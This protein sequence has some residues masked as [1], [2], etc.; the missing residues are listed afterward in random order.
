VLYGKKRRWKK[1]Q[2][3]RKLV[4]QDAKYG[5]QLPG[6][7]IESTVLRQSGC[8]WLMIMKAKEGYH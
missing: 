4:L 1:G 8:V 2:I 5:N 7:V 3:A 6:A